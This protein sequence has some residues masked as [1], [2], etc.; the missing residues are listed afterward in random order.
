MGVNA[1]MASLFEPGIQ[2]VDLTRLPASFRDGPDY[3]NAMRVLDLPAVVALVADARPV[4]LVEP[5][6][7]VWEYAEAV[8]VGLGWDPN[9]VRVRSSGW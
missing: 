6:Q 9:R 7:G 5:A 2:G 1:L 3:L 4:R 8:S